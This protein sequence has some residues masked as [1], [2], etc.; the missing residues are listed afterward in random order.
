MHVHRIVT[1]VSFVVAVIALILTS[2]WN[3]NQNESNRSTS[4]SL[5]NITSNLDILQTE[6]LMSQNQIVEILMGSANETI[7][8]E[9]TFIWSIGG[10]SYRN[11]GGF[12]NFPSEVV[13]GFVVDSP[14]NGYRVGDLVTLDTGTLIQFYENAV[15]KVTA[16][17]LLGEVLAFDVLTP[18]CVGYNPFPL[19]NSSFNSLSVVGSGFTAK[20]Y[21]G[22]YPP[23]NQSTYYIFYTPQNN[24]VAPLQYAN[25]SLRKIAFKSMEYIVLYLSS[26]EFP[27]V[28][29]YFPFDTTPF[30][31]ALTVAL[32]EFNPPISELQ[33][34][35]DSNYYFPLT[36]K[37]LLAINLTD[38]TDC[39]N[40]NPN[41][42]LDATGESSISS[43]DA[44]SFVYV[45]RGS[46]PASRKAYIRWHFNSGFPT[47]DYVN[48]NATLFLNYPLMIVFPNV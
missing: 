12:C 20:R 43:P 3:S 42:F 27:I 8:Q 4:R 47:Y 26:P 16:V 39:Y 46:N 32:Y 28:T 13:T 48:A 33:T 31:N 6:H 22:P 19:S 45:S 34:L 36:R 18:G 30:S 37:N 2:V 40:S 9:G 5:R 29:Q 14:G 7:I 24:P 10:T 1:S 23:I 11:I 15:L 21:A 44:I 17:G 41:C 25:Y 35:G 38:A